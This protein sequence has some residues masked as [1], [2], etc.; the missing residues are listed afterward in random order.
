MEKKTRNII[1]IGVAVLLLVL[2]AVLI[3][4]FINPKKTN[5]ELIADHFEKAFGKIETV[6]KDGELAQYI[7]KFDEDT[8]LKITS[9]TKVVVDE[10][11]YGEETLDFD[12]EL[13][14]HGTEGVYAQILSE[15][16]DENL[17]LEFLLDYKNSR[18][19]HKLND[20]YSRFYY[21]DF[22]ELGFDFSDFEASL[23][24]ELPELDFDPNLLFDYFVETF[25]ET[26]KDEMVE[27]EEKEIKLGGE[28]YT[29]EKITAKFTEK[30]LYEML[31]LYVKKLS[32]D[33]KLMEALSDYLYETTGEEFEIDDLIDEIDDMIDE[34][35]DKS[36]LFKYSMCL[37]KGDVVS[38]EFV[39]SIESDEQDVDIKLVMNTYENKDKNDVEEVYLSLMGI[40]MIS[41]EIEHKNENDFDFEFSIYS[42][43]DVKGSFEADDNDFNLKVKGNI[44]NEYDEDSEKTEF[45]NLSLEGKED[46]KDKYKLNLD[47][48]FDLDD[49]VLDVDSKNTVSIEDKMPKIDLS[50][51]ADVSEMTDDELDAYEEIFG[52]TYEDDYDYDYDYDFDDEDYDYDFDDEDY[53]FELDY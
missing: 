38:N 35:D 46:G 37:Y 47:L 28:K 44:M 18:L 22:S 15:L 32:K 24:E 25:N 48:H 42:S 34:A 12:L 49:V 50:D 1:F 8:V 20:V 7:E 21:Q 10:Y 13:Y 19:Y 17:D 11:D 51:A 41:F 3:F 9:D 36:T 4:L 53:D 23:E 6:V 26:V 14:S 45:L 2:A 5:K 43:M 39:V 30:D 33:K 16:E 27:S 29:V 40:K 52:G 31:K